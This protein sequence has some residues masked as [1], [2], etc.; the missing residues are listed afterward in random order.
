M[1]NIT[2]L[3]KA[4]DINLEVM[5][6]AEIIETLELVDTVAALS[7]ECRAYLM[8][9]YDGV[10]L[11]DA[12]LDMALNHAAL[13]APYYTSQFSNPSFG[14]TA[15]GVKACR[16][17]K[18]VPKAEF[19]ADVG[20]LTMSAIELAAL[21][22]QYRKSNTL[23]CDVTAQGWPINSDKER[24]EFNRRLNEQ[25]R[26]QLDDACG[27]PQ[28]AVGPAMVVGGYVPNGKCHISTDKGC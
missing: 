3:L 20:T 9:R 19:G 16:I 4:A 24:E 13:V 18:A 26:K 1:I 6:A 2:K 22:E 10:R 15:K 27:I 12:R 8:D 17:I 14:V 7:K 21:N 5:S 23:A 28:I 25:C 11:S